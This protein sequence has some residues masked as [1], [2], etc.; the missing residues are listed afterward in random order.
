MCEGMGYKVRVL[1]ATNREGEISQLE[2]QPGK[3][4]MRLL[5]DSGFDEMQAVCGGSCSCATCHVYVSGSAVA[6]LAPMSEDEDELLSSSTYR[7]DA[8]RLSCQIQVTDALAG[9]EVR[10]APED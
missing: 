10:L 9:L 1:L 5:R 4:L 3:S 2:I 6:M 7:R 8:S